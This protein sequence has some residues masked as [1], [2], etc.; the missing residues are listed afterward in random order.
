MLHGRLTVRGRQLLCPKPTSGQLM[1]L[2]R[3]AGSHCTSYHPTAAATARATTPQ[4]QPL[5]VSLEHRQ[6]IFFVSSAKLLLAAAAASA[7]TAV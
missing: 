5:R 4:Q 3:A 1:V 6:K 2:H 7:A